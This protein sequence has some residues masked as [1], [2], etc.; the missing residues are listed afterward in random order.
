MTVLVEY[1]CAAC[2]VHHEAW[3]E[4]PIPAVISCASCA[5]P[6]RRRF[7]GALMRAA[8]PPEAPAVQ[9]R[10]SC[11]EAPDIPGICTLIPTAARSLAARARRDTRALEAEIAHQEAAIAAGTLDPTASPVTPY[12][13]HHP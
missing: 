4:R 5:C 3:A 9:D 12:H 11:R 2:R 7:G 1:V 10:T 8:S 6:A 13:G